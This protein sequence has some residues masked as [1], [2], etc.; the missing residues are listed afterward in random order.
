MFHKNPNNKKQD[1]QKNTANKKGGL[2]APILAITIALVLLATLS[3]H[4]LETPTGRATTGSNPPVGNAAPFYS[5]NSTNTTRAGQPV[6]HRLLWNDSAGLSGYIFSFD[7]CTGTLVNDSWTPFPNGGTQDW[8][9]VTKIV[10][11]TR[12][13]TI[14]WCVYANNSLGGWNSSCNPP[15]SYTTTNN[16]PEIVANQSFQDWDTPG[17]DVTAT[18]TDPDG[19]GDITNCTLYYSNPRATVYFYYHKQGIYNPATGECTSNISTLDYNTISWENTSSDDIKPNDM[20]VDDTKLYINSYSNRFVIVNKTTG[21]YILRQSTLQTGGGI[22]VDDNYVYI[23][24]YGNTNSVRKY[25]KDGTLV[26]TS[27]NW[28]ETINA[29]DID[30]EYVYAGG[31]K[32]LLTKLNKT[33]LTQIVW[34]ANYTSLYWIYDLDVS[35]DSVYL[36]MRQ[37]TIKR[38]NKTDNATIWSTTENPSAY[39]YAILY[40]GTWVWAGDNKGTLY[41]INKTD[42]TTVWSGNITTG[43]INDMTGDQNYL[44]ITTSHGEVIRLD[45]TDNTAITLYNF[46]TPQA[47]LDL[48]A[49]TSDNTHLYIA[50]SNTI[51]TGYSTIFK[52]DK[53]NQTRFTPGST[54]ATKIRFTDSYGDHA[55]TNIDTHTILPVPL[56][57]TENPKNKT[58]DTTTIWLNIT[59]SNDTDSCWYSLDTGANTTM[60][61]DTST[62][63]YALETGLAQGPHR[64]SFYCNNTLSRENKTHIVFTIDTIPPKIVF[65][66]PTPENDTTLYQSWVVVNTS[67]TD[68]T[69]TTGLIDW[70]HT[71]VVWLRFNNETGE[72]NTFYRDWSGHGNN[73]TGLDANTTNTDADTPPQPTTGRFGKGL[74]FDGVDDY[75]RIQD[76]PDFTFGAND[77]FTIEAWIKTE[78]KGYQAIVSTYWGGTEF[79]R[80]STNA[81]GIWFEFRDANS[82]LVAVHPVGTEDYLDGKWHYVAGVRD[83][84]SGMA[85]LY[86]D[87]KLEDNITDTTNTTIDSGE[88]HIGNNV[89]GNYWFNGTIDEVRIW[90]RALSPQEINASYNAGL[91]GL[92]A[93]YTGLENGNYTFRAYAQDLAGNVNQTQERTI[94]IEAPQEYYISDCAVLDQPEATYFLTTDITDS[95]AVTCMNITANN[96]TLDCQGHLIDGDDSA[97]YGIYVYR[98]SSQTTNITIKNCILKDWDSA[99]IYFGKAHGNTLENITTY[100]SPDYGIYLSTTPTLTP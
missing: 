19:T 100:S 14:R 29:L 64:V 84:R 15:F 69:N 97:D 11:T 38:V 80:I 88:I 95:P 76:S 36:A 63:Y 98:S 59:T 51:S 28:G 82:N 72:N 77:S 83:T 85:Y 40:D 34:Q 8:S 62:H 86:I 39:V 16:P 70:N 60:S 91:H 9:N 68:T 54:V 57:W 90:R 74:E 44:Y 37:G 23:G 45:K 50:E 32:G 67:I 35:N 99:N 73:G 4:S 79:F 56:I 55:E 2:G 22:A 46:T 61:N 12:G 49:V 41:K 48:Q 81:S 75:V 7:N 13:C 47:T 17:Y 5:D 26:E 43:A 42:G 52:L 31:G 33:N 53:N 24:M 30:D 94:K 89:N 78:Y 18:A 71:L 93:N 96:I 27:Q 92:Y 1:L 21:D 3:A 20:A 58:Y 25:T 6:E 65:T 87:G 10:N 66:P